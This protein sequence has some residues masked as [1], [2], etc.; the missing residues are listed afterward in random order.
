MRTW[1]RLWGGDKAGNAADPHEIL[2][3]YGN[4]PM[5]VH[6]TS[7]LCV[8]FNS[9]NMFLRLCWHL[10]PRWW[11]WG[12]KISL[13]SPIFHNQGEDW[14]WK[15]G[16]TPELFLLLVLDVSSWYSSV[17][18]LGKWLSLCLNYCSIFFGVCVYDKTLW[19]KQHSSR[20]DVHK[21]GEGTAA[22]SWNITSPQHT[23]NRK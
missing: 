16:H 3:T 1:G 6:P 18:S 2:F 21:S 11:N 14:D 20:L 13:T 19:Q 4:T 7:L 9:H 15:W 8:H 17:R 10:L 23:G 12:S 5:E 22:E